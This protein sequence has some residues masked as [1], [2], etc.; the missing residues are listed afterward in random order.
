MR[1]IVTTVNIVVIN[2]SFFPPLHKIPPE[3]KGF[4]YSGRTLEGS[5]LQKI[6]DFQ[7]VVT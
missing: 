6:I 2:E 3:S 7:N 4:G 1:S 5:F